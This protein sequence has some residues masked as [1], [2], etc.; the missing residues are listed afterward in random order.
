MN[1]KV[2]QVLADR[3]QMQQVLLNLIMNAIEAMSS[4][5]SRE[6]VLTVKSEE[7]ESNHVLITLQD[8]GT[9]IDSAHMDRIFDAFFTTKDR[10][11]GM[12]LAIC[13][14]IIE[15]HGGQL[16]AAP[17]NPHGTSFYVKLVKAPSDNG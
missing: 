12:G 10:G 2:P 3:V 17:L 9:G 8:S 1:D 4:T 11:M 5:T 14:S 6:R 15:S 7:F 16:W 13:R